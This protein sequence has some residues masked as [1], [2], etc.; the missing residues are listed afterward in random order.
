M[1]EFQKSKKLKGILFS[2]VTFFVLLAFSIVLMIGLF[3]I[4]PK[5]ISTSRTK[6]LVQDQ[7]NSLK[8]QSDALA[9]DIEKLKTADG[10][11]EKIRE[12][13]RVVREGEGLVVIVDD[14]SGKTTEPPEKSNT[15]WGFWKNLFKE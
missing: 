11:E 15:F 6:E 13:F 12:K 14:Q 3:N 9:A 8:I 2:K 5:E 1:A 4:I 7:L 10:V